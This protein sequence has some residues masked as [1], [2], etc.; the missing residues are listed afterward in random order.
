[1]LVFLVQTNPVELRENVM[2]FF[3]LGQSRLSVI[4]RRPY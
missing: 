4:M 2:A 3:P 1:M